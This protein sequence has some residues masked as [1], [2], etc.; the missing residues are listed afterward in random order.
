MASHPGGSL[1]VTAASPLGSMLPPAPEVTHTRYIMHPLLRTHC[2]PVVHHAIMA[3]ATTTAHSIWP[4]T[5]AQATDMSGQRPSHLS[6]VTGWVQ[7]MLNL[8]PAEQQEAEPEGAQGATW[9]D[10]EHALGFLVQDL[11]Q[12]VGSS[13]RPVVVFHHYGFDQCV[14]TRSAAG[15]GAVLAVLQVLAGLLPATRA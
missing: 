2:V 14:A 7:V 5:S 12:A 13:G 15:S 4:A 6:G 11:A 10:P 8:A 1:P 3:A 9:N